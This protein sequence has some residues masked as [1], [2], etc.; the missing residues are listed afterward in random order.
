MPAKE[1]TKPTKTKMMTSNQNVYI[2]LMYFQNIYTFMQF[3]RIISNL[4]SY[5]FFSLAV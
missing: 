2:L 5:F 3:A 1:R 4:F